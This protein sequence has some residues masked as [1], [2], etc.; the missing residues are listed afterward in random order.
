MENYQIN[1]MSNVRSK[2]HVAFRQGLEHS[3]NNKINKAISKTA[4]KH[5]VKNCNDVFLYLQILIFI[6]IRILPQA[7]T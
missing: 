1:F 4:L 5:A 2:I 3:N 6:Q 7:F